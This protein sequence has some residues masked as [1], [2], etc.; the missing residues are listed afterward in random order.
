MRNKKIELL[1]P[2]GSWE[3]LE[4]AV[5][6][7]ADA[8]YMGGKSFGARAY[9]SNFDK[10][11]MAKA[12]YFAHMHRVR[13]YITVNTLVDDSEL[14]ALADYL[15]FLNNVGVDGVIV[16]DLGVIR[17]A[18]K[19]VP[20][21]P[22]HA[23]TQMTITNSSGV[24]FAVT[25]G[26]ERSVLARE[27]SLKEIEAACAKGS[28]IETFIHGALCVCYSG[29]CLMSSLIGGRSGNRGRCAQPCRLPYKLMN[30]QG[31]D[32]L[33]G[34]DVGQ[35][36]LSPKDMNTLEILPQLIEAGVV[37]YKIEGRMKRPEYVAI[38]VD[39]YRRAIDSYL[40]GDFR[41]PHEDFA[42]IE[43]IFNR[44]FTTAYLTHRLGKEM[45]SDRRPNNRGV[46]I[47]RVTKI[48]KQHNKAVV[49]LDKEIHLGDGLEFWVSVGGRVGTT[50]SEMLCNGNSVAL[51]KPGQQVTIDVPN[52]VR[53][54]DRVFRTLDNKL[55]DYA[56]KFYGPE[57][58]K[59]IPVDMVVTAKVGEPMTVF[60]TDDEGNT[61]FGVTNF[62]S[63][64]A[65]KRAL[66]DATVYKQMNRLGT[67]EYFLNSLV[68]EHDGN[69]MVPMSEMNEARRMAC[70]ALDAARL[71]YFA[72]ARTAVYKHSEKLRPLA[73]KNRHIVSK[74]TVHCDS[75]AKVNSALQA[76]AERILF[77]GD[78]FNHQLPAHQDYIKVAEMCRKAGRQFAFATPRI[79]K[80][81][82]LNYFN[83]LFALWNE[84]KPDFVYINNNGL[85]PLAKKYEKLVLFADTSLNIFNSQTL[86]FWQEQGAVGATLSAELTMA[87]IEHLVTVTPIPLEC[88]VQGRLEMMVSEY[89]VGGSFLGDLHQGNCKFNCREK[90]FLGDR[91]DAQFPI[92]TDQYC[93]MHILN[94]HE[95]SLLANVQHLQE[96]GV[97]S[98][99]IDGRDY[100]ETRLGELIT[101]YRRV[102]GG[103][104][105]APENLPGTTRGH[106]F[107]GVL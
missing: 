2:A 72:P 101:L 92:V 102:L 67:T 84:L 17:L 58:K 38:V 71:E 18:R 9:A 105:E 75:L 25:A 96:I 21:L 57:A 30:A 104:V 3:A 64:E 16:Q 33:Q 45:M 107:R 77:G 83:K 8:V 100:D 34:K 4:A 55:M 39:A 73:H 29:Q 80:E 82:Q 43:Q 28:E 5:N 41:I 40:A 23:S 106:Y 89:C 6:A 32:M 10:E 20:Q 85:W 98:L 22:L 49:K 27:L 90:L 11:E 62:I 60:L 54:N 12:V 14:E 48:D 81:D 50:V 76:G 7:G 63:E 99:R 93:R 24:D 61:G 68:F 47:G 1:A 95:L 87:Q 31:D 70:E 51:A 59:R 103:A 19:I 15:L 65:R 86:Q 56:Q 74:L 53:F 79:I 78:C 42:N 52:G 66:D 69:V 97:E 91:K 94:A 44:D 37:S 26:M 13:L 36:L 46:L 88:M 35:Y